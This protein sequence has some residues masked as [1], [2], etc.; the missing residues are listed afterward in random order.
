MAG[1]L[2]II[3]QLIHSQGGDLA[4]TWVAKPG[5]HA[6]DSTPRKTY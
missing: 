2:S 6:E 4:S 3:V 1:P 5:V